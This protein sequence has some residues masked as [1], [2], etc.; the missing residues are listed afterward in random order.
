MNAMLVSAG[1][2]MKRSSAAHAAAVAHDALLR[3]KPLV[4]QAGAV[5]HGAAPADVESAETEATQ[6]EVDALL[7]R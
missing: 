5:I 7:E 6:A 3:L 1:E 2:T 4:A